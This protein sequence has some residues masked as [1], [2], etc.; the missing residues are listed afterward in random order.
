LA[1]ATGGT[2]TVAGTGKVGLENTTFG[3]G[4]YTASGVVTISSINMGDTIAIGATD[5]TGKLALAG[6]GGLTLGQKGSDAGGATYTLTAGDAGEKVTLGSNAIVIP[7]AD[8][9]GAS[10]A[11]ADEFAGITIGTG[12]IKLDFATGKSGGSL[13]LVEGNTIGVFDGG[14]ITKGATNA[15]VTTF[16]TA[17]IDGTKKNGELD[18][19]TNNGTVTVKAGD[20][21]LTGKTTGTG[22]VISVG[23]SVVTD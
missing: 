21:L 18:N 12:T 15:E 20:L 1:L 8:T 6:A 13:E 22:D 9:T 3:A 17:D 2:I 7:Y 11:A 10:V 5:G 23:I 4:T 16:G 19:T 14:T